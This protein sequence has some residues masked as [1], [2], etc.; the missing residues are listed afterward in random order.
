MKKQTAILV[1]VNRGHK[2]SAQAGAENVLEQ[3]ADR[4]FH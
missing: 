1:A 3:T 4:G 2:V